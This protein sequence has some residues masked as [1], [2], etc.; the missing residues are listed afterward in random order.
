MSHL[1]WEYNIEEHRKTKKEEG[2]R[3]EDFTDENGNFRF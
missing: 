3:L 1:K 2:F